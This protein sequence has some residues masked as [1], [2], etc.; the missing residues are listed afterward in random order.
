MHAFVPGDPQPTDH[1]DSVGRPTGGGSLTLAQG[2]HSMPVRIFPNFPH[3][4]RLHFSVSRVMPDSHQ[5][6]FFE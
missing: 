4:T 1:A 5:F 2:S 3:T 6:P